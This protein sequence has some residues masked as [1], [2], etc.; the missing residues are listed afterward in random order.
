MVGR[1][2]IVLRLKRDARELAKVLPLLLRRE[3]GRH[4][5]R[6]VHLHAGL[7]RHDFENSAGLGIAHFGGEFHLADLAVENEVVVIPVVHRL[8]ALLR[9]HPVGLRTNRAR[10]AEVEAGAVNGRVLRRDEPRV[11]LSILVG[12]DHEKLVEDIAARLAREVPVGMMRRIDDSRL[13]SRRLV[14]DAPDVLR[15]DG[16][17]DLH[18]DR[19]GEAHV[20]VGRDERQ[21]KALPVVLRRLPDLGIPAA[22]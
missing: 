17:G 9:R 3:F 14:L 6:T 2:G 8:Q 18:R 21:H 1:V 13:V 5:L 19:A 12:V 7:G 4:V 22:R 15:K 10:L 20:A 16:V 11:G